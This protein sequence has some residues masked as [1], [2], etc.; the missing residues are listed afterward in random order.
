MQQTF[1]ENVS[2]VAGGR[3]A[4][5]DGDADR[6]I[7]FYFNDNSKFS[8]LDGDKIALLFAEHLS[9]LAEKGNLQLKTGIVQTA[10][11]NGSSTN[12]ARDVLVK[13]L[14]TIIMLFHLTYL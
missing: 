6:L 10:Y 13:T 4:S 8:M 9:Q 12:Y 7:Y 2:P 1:P 11:A 5:L 3:F 14:M